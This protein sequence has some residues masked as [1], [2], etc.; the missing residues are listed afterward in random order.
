MKVTFRSD[1]DPDLALL[2]QH[3]E[4]GTFG[5]LP[6]TWLHKA[7]QDLNAL[8]DIIDALSKRMPWLSDAQRAHNVQ[9]G[10]VDLP[11]RYDSPTQ[12]RILDGLVSRIRSAAETIGLNTVDFP[13]YSCIPTGLV[14]ASAVVLPDATRPFLL[15][16]SELFLYC[17]LFSKAFAHCLPIVGRGEMLS[18]SVD[19]ELVRERLTATPELVER[20]F[21][22]LHAYATTGSPSQ[23][24]QYNPE[25]DYVH[26]VDILRDSME[27]FVVAHEFGHVY[28]G[29]L[30]ELLQR[31]G[32]QSVDVSSENPSHRQEYEADLL[33]L[34]LT[35][36]AMVSRGYD[37]ALSYVGIELFFVSL[38][39]AAR[40]THLIDHGTDDTYIDVQ[41]ESH[42]SNAERRSVLRGA[43]EILVEDEQQVNGARKMSSKY[44]AIADLLWQATK[45]ANPSF[46]RTTELNH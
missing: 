33:G 5:E 24:K 4:S 10:D 16:D 12:F 29:H 37:T 7:Q 46:Q 21:D 40:A 44:V 27:L 41:S 8:Q 13:H 11:T 26:L 31:C 42:P 1:I 2:E 3:L 32:L 34:L 28:A 25:A 20:L 9:F 18:L 45:V 43:L 35:L 17:H 19:V 30:S 22:L 14:N 6:A 36:Q 23:S 15:F 38:D 39:M